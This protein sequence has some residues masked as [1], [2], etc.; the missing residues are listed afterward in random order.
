LED[1]VGDW[2]VRRNYSSV[3]ARPGKKRRRVDY[4]TSTLHKWAIRIEKWLKEVSWVYVYF[5][6]DVGGCA[7]RTARRLKQLLDARKLH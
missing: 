5:N 2:S 4:S 6:N 3:S 1:I 7:V